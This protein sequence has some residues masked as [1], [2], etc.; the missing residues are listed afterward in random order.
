MGLFFKI[1]KILAKWKSSVNT[2]SNLLTQ[3]MKTEQCGIRSKSSMQKMTSHGHSEID[4]VK[5]EWFMKN[6]WRLTKRTIC[7]NFHIGNGSEIPMKTSFRKEKNNFKTITTLF[8]LLL[9]SRSCQ[10]CSNF[11]TGLNQKR[12]R[13]LRK[14]HWT[15]KKTKRAKWTNKSNWEKSLTKS[16]NKP[17][18][19]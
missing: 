18:Q 13:K 1:I 2:S 5:W 9:I 7:Q 19:N 16:P 11:L 14:S 3:R 6:V 8:F 4:T 10:I 12:K 17:N 15:N